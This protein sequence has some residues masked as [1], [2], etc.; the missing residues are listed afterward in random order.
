MCPEGVYLGGEEMRL[1]KFCS[2]YIGF[3]EECQ[4]IDVHYR[5][6]DGKKGKQSWL[7]CAACLK[8]YNLGS[9]KE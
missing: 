5:M 9:V 2:R 6:K 8:E 1:C 7:C 4:Y 3:T